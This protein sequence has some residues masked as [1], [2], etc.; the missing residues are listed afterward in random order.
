MS[1]TPLTLLA[2][3][4]ASGALALPACGEGKEASAPGPGANTVPRADL[5]RA[6]RRVQ[7]LEQEVKRLPDELERL[8][9]EQESGEASATGEAGA[10]GTAGGAPTGAGA[11]SA[12]GGSAAGGSAAGGS[13]GPGGTDAGGG[14]DPGSS[15]ANP[16][17]EDICGT[18]PAPEC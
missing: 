16:S 12:G 11:G 7:E 9:V 4:L 8:R 10:G 6:E 18:N 1:P 5:D 15:E 17:V 13:G 14:P 3:V 2:C